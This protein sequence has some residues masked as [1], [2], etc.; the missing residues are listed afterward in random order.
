MRTFARNLRRELRGLSSSQIE[1]LL[2]A[3]SPHTLAQLDGLWEVWARSDQLPP[4]EAP[5]GPAWRT[6]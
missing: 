1:R 5:A 6:W 3:L 2:D 4:R